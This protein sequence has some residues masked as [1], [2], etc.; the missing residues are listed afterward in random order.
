MN[1]RV[2]HT[3]F[4]GVYYDEHLK[5]S[6]HISH[7][8]NRL[9]IVAGMLF[10]LKLI[11]P[12]KILKNIY[13]SHVNSILN[14][15]TPIWCCNYR[16]NIN[17]VLL[18]QKRIIRCVT[19]SDYLAHSQPLFK[20]CHA[21]NIFDINKAYL[22]NLCYKNPA[23]YVDPNIQQ[24][25]HATRNQNQLRPARFT[26]TLAMNSFLNQGPLIYNQV[27]L[28]IKQS[29]TVK[30]FKRKLKDHFLTSY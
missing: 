25:G 9:A 27:P 18:L 22:S 13:N 17:P 1:K 4:L 19:K 14:Y 8:C 20:K 26:T 21:L 16:G 2:D 11:L 30:S 12:T 29:M 28:A 6:Q 5:F 7:L 24:H 23:K 15:C 10:R 3:K